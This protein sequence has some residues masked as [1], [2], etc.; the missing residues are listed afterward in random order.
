[1]LTVTR[2]AVIGTDVIGTEY[3]YLSDF[4]LVLAVC[5]GL[6]FL[7]ARFGPWWAPG[8]GAGRTTPHVLTGRLPALVAT[9]AVFALIV[10]STLSTAAFAERWTANPARIWVENAEKAIP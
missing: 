6:A 9:A 4:A 10:N 3:R 7:P 1:V 2:G 8:D 5:G